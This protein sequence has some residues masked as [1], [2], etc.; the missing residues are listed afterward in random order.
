MRFLRQSLFGVFLASV[1][2]ALLIWAGEL[3]KDAVQAR[4]TADK[5]VPSANERVF[6]VNV[7]LA[8]SGTVVP[9]LEAFGQVKSRRTLELRSAMGGRVVGLSENFVEG[10]VVREG[11]VLVRIDPAKA[12]TELDRARSDLMDAEAEERDAARALVLARDELQAAQDQAALRAQAMKRQQDLVERGVGSAAT[13]ETAELAYAQARQA[14]LARRIAVAQAE[15]RVDQAATRLSRAHLALDLAERD[16]AETEILAGFDGTLSGVTLV[17][18]RLVS[19]NEKLAELVDPDA[20]EVAFRVSTAQYSRLLDASGQLVGAPVMVHLDVAGADLV[21]EGSISRDSVAAGEGQSGRVIYARLT[22]A[23][24][25]KPGDFVTV[26][27]DEPAIEDVV[28]LPASALDAAGT[29]LVLDAE[30]RLEVLPVTLLRRQEDSVLVRGEGLE[31]REVVVGRT[32]LLGPGVKVRPLRIE[33]QAREPDLSL[34][35]LSD[36]RRARLVALVEDNDR[37]PADVKE[38]LL[39]QL[40]ETR[41]PARLVQRLEDRAGG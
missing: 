35:E 41:V 24:G 13:A 16:L 7:Q 26:Q 5:K 22:S 3:V 36:E 9:V 29:V 12:Q 17:E 10:G 38:R 33:A 28:R 32:P 23:R 27:V 11:E 30:D 31:G 6:A 14:V 18:G 21:A 37:M 39:G 4:L 15:A 25:F 19:V 34:L 8:E 2:L 20:L 40:A 1:A